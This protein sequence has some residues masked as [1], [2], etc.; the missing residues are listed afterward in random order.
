MAPLSKQKRH[1]KRV[2][3]LL[4]KP[5]TATQESASHD[6][7]DL[8]ASPVPDQAVIPDADF[9]AIDED[10]DSWVA[11]FDE[12][13]ID[14]M[15]SKPWLQWKKGAGKQFRKAYDGTGRSS[16][17]AK[18]A[19]KRRRE[20]LMS[21]SKDLYEYLGNN[22][23]LRPEEDPEIIEEGSNNDDGSSL[24]SFESAIEKL[25][26]IVRISSNQRIQ[27]NT[28]KTKFEFSRHLAVLRFL[29][30]IKENPRSRIRSS[31]DVTEQIF[32][33]D[34]SRAKNIWNWSDEYARTRQMMVLRQGKH[35]KTE[36]LID[37]SDIRFALLAFLRTVRPKIID[38]ESLAP[39]ISGKFTSSAW[40]DIGQPC[41]VSSK[42]SSSM[43]A[44]FGFP[45]LRT[46][47]RN[48]YRWA[49]KARRCGPS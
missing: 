34:E 29:E 18:R 3:E 33:K 30:K 16:V 41:Q 28:S 24:F 6:A 38:G 2:A 1:I 37:D 10:L 4:W 48:V 47:V 13:Q 8:S 42:Y 20:Q 31:K 23:S 12:E 19:E 40:V 14:E 27:M 11:C 17:F 9:E 21:Q 15:W 43:V 7:A 22:N 49:R 35:Q 36:S 5:T 25:N 32:G 45:Q 39:W 46:Q 44:Q 26:S